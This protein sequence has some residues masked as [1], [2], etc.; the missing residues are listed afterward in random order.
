M[1][2]L[3][4]AINDLSQLFRDPKTLIFFLALPIAFTFFMGF[5]LQSMVEPDDP[6]IILGWVNDDPDGFLSQ[7]LYNILSE[8]QAV[9]LVEVE[10]SQ[11]AT[12]LR[13]GK[14]AGVLSVPEDFSANAVASQPA[15]LTLLADP[16]SN[17]TQSL[18]QILHTP[19]TQIMGSLEI[20]RINSE[21]S[22]S[23]ETYRTGKENQAEIEATFQSAVQAW[24]A[25]YT[26]G[27][28]VVM[29]KATA[30][31]P[32]APLGGNPYN[33]T[34]PGIL[35]QFTIF[36]TFTSALILV[37]ERKN[38]CLQRL[39]TTALRPYEVI[40]GHWLAMFFM[41]F[42]QTAMLIVFGQLVLEVNYLGSPLGTLLVAITLCLWVASM[43]LLIGIFAKGDEQAILLS[44]A[45]ML[46]FASLGGA[47]VPLDV[48]SK[49]F[50]TVGHLTPGA[51]AMDGFQNILVRGLGTSSVIQPAL[52]LSG[53][54]LIFFILAV[55]RFRKGA[56]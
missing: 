18:Q 16:L 14:V 55:W 26:R 12:Q 19:I 1:R 32:T 38:R 17:T 9:R 30:E 7:Q 52:I 45:A 10:A 4:L 46:I 47:N 49:L 34:S 40:A 3:H 22:D 27:G 43:G 56:V 5:A 37:Q 44:M 15:Q 35:V 36:Q 25:S 41:L 24:A 28:F 54:A 20:A 51:W 13:S 42:A 6:R 39:M 23:E 33:Q 21:L 2:T 8:S 29:E 11:A 48:S 50:Y 53:F 31:E